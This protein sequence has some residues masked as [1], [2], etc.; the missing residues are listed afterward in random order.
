LS[1][2]FLDHNCGGD[3]PSSAMNLLPVAQTHLHGGRD[4]MP[5]TPHS[6]RSAS[7]WRPFFL[8]RFLTSAAL[9]ISPADAEE[10]LTQFHCYQMTVAIEVPYWL[11]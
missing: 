8:R 6:G 1:I 9:T 4:C 5:G 11:A 10:H 2:R 3:D 7:R